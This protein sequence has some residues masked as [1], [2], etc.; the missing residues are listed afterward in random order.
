MADIFPGLEQ[1]S[2]LHF[3]MRKLIDHRP[4]EV[5]NLLK[6]V[7]HPWT[8]EIGVQRILS[9]AQW[10]IGLVLC[11]DISGSPGEEMSVG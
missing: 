9:K 2:L 7:I 4:E 6:L 5:K 10:A 3:E 8:L 11:A 1:F